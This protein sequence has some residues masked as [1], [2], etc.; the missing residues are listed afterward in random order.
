MVDVFVDTPTGNQHGPPSTSFWN[1][2][3]PLGA[4]PF[5]SL[6]SP[7][8]HRTQRVFG[9]GT[10]SNLQK[11]FYTPSVCGDSELRILSRKAWIDK[12][13]RFFKRQQIIELFGRRLIQ[14]TKSHFFAGC[15]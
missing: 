9:Q 3:H 1:E 12:S 13:K 14:N 4:A 8:L 11:D 6:R 2:Q 10:Q 7:S 15:F 5:G